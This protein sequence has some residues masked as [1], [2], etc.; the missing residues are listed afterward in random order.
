M[1]WVQTIFAHPDHLV[2]QCSF[3]TT[4]LSSDTIN[5]TGSQTYWYVMF[6]EEWE[7]YTSLGV[8]CTQMAIIDLTNVVISF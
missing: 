2:V 3:H 1:G 7:G 5:Q 8:P 4:Y 6:F